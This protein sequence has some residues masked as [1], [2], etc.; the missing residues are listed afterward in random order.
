MHQFA[1]EKRFLQAQIIALV[2]MKQIFDRVI[3]QKAPLNFDYQATTPCS[4]EVVAAM[5]PYWYELWGNASSGYSRASLHASA[6]L[7]LAREQLA[8]CLG[9]KPERLIFT[10]GATEANNLALLGYARARSLSM[11]RPGHLITL[12]TEHSSVID[13]LRQLQKEGFQLTEMKPSSD[14]IL[15]PEKL[16]EAFQDDTILVS[17]MM[18]NNEIGVIQPLKEFSELCKKRGVILHSD[19]S[20]AFGQ[21]SFDIDQ[22]EI[23]FLSFSGHKIYGPKGIGALVIRNE[24]PI[25]PLQWGG[26]Q[27]QGI[28][29]GTVPIPLVIG[30]AKAAELAFNNLNVRQERISSL[31][32]E[33]WNRLSEKIPDLIINGSMEHRLPNNLNFTILGVRGSMLQNSLRPLLNCS[34]GSACSQGK[35]SHVLRA[36]GRTKEEAEAS[37][38]ISIGRETTLEEVD[39]AVDILFDAISRLRE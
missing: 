32:N 36:I 9:I 24:L 14:G 10:S 25:I 28:R 3:N 37:L 21:F 19:A 31:R 38:R 8:T 34:S 12:A 27:E 29:S 30:M 13:P 5:E 39:S 20:Q 18:A 26:G 11:R 1:F 35:P 15:L 17:I 7:S 6:A 23:D 4:H 22:L 2:S 33:F 16:E